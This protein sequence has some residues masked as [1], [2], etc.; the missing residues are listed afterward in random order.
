LVWPG[1]TIVR[2]TKIC[3]DKLANTILKFS[4]CT[5]LFA[6]N[7]CRECQ[8][9]FWKAVMEHDAGSPVRRRAS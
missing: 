4:H 7:G 1:R 6:L 5:A 9:R 2:E 3:L 8:F